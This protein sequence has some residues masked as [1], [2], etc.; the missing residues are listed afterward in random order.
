MHWFV[1]TNIRSCTLIT[2]CVHTDGVVERCS[3][4]GIVF[5]RIA[6]TLASVVSD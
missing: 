1:D 3:G 6:I 5:S 4:R 2:Y